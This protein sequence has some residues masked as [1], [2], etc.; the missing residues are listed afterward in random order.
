MG[1]RLV[2]MAGVCAV[3]LFFPGCGCSQ[4]KTELDTVA[5]EATGAAA[6]RRGQEVKSQLDQIQNTR[7]DQARQALEE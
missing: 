4:A 5:D 3:M 2:L 1:V 7:N 6:V